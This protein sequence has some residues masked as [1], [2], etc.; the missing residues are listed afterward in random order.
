[1]GSKNVLAS[2]ATLEVVYLIPSRMLV[3]SYEMFIWHLQ[4]RIC[5]SFTESGMTSARLIS[6][7][8]LNFLEKENLENLELLILMIN[9]AN[10]T[11][12]FGIEIWTRAQRMV[13]LRR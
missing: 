9:F 3:L 4:R 10:N 2:L 1:M 13:G 8:K 6:I 7:I 5:S 11:A 12:N